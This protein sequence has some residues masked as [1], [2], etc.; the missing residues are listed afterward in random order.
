MRNLYFLVIIFLSYS[1]YG[2][3]NLYVSSYNWDKTPNY[4]LP[5][6]SEEPMMALKE[7]YITEFAYSDNA[8]TEHYLEHKAFWLNS[9]E[10]IEAYNKIYLPYSTNSELLENK[11]RVITK[12]GKIIDL[13]ESKILTAQDEETGKHYKYFAFEGVEKGS[14]IEYFYVEKKKPSYNGIAFRL[15]SD[16]DKKN[17]D[18]D[19]YSP[20]NLV[21]QFKSYNGLPDVVKDTLSKNRLHW[22]LSLE[23]LAGLQKEEQAPYAAS[24][25]Y[26][27]YKLDKNLKTNKS[28]LSSYGKVAQ[29]IYNYY[30]TEPS[31][32]A[33]S[34]I[35]E[36][37]ASSS[38][39]N[40]DLESKIRSIDNLIKSGFILSE[41]GGENLKNLEEILEKKVASST[42]MIK[43]Y[44]ALLRHLQIAHEIVI[45]S[46]RKTLKFDKD[47]EAHNFLKDFLIYFPDLKT[48]LSPT[49][50]QSRY[51]YPPAFLT[52]NYGLFIKEVSVGSFKS[53]IGKIKYIE[54]LS[55]DKTIDKMIIDVQF[56]QEDLTYNSI[57]LQRSFSGYYAMPFHPYMNQIIGDNRSEMMEGLAKTMNENI[58]VKKM[59]LVNESPDLFG[60]KPIGFI[61]DLKSDAFVEKA[62]RKYLFK[63]GELIGPQIEM[64]QE[65]K[66]VL[67]LE[68][69]HTRSYYRT[70]N[71][72]LPKGYRVVNLDELNIE[73]KYDENGEE[74][75][76]FTSFYELKD[77]VLS[78]TAD[79]HY[80]TNIVA[81]SIFVKFR[82]V[83]NTA[84]DFNKITLILEPEG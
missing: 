13:D 74:L 84:A 35:Q 6:D 80:R 31:K 57:K 55:A 54:P 50:M 83:I 65:K 18:F 20:S 26:L 42:G 71:I 44:V 28:D 48:Y 21:F 43:L 56:D 36:F 25:G 40:N 16:F 3:D 47:F 34:Q 7:K 52:D 1:I 67:P 82:K 15:Q 29:N 46:N 17:V 37:A 62:G 81:P 68:N 51:G 32:K 72:T 10:K 79:E 4:K 49:D 23:S 33:S 66:R 5:V 69:E 63:L 78:I 70:L 77:N 53:A 39:N 11:A 2:Q 30:Y 61:I 58:E 14:V 45:T 75:F 76:S 41:S 22:K 64:Y 9:N 60:I 24:R 38:K 8:F 59:E 12:N 27:I 73:N 19:L